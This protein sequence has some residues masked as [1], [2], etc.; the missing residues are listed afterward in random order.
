MQETRDGALV[1][2]HD[3]QRVL[4]ASRRAVINEG[5][6][7]QLAAEVDDLGRAVVQVGCSDSSIP[8]CQVFGL[9]VN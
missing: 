9:Y 7:A 3:L 1:V 8:S 4:G 6:V 2:L 5:V